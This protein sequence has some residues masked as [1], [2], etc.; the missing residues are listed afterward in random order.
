MDGASKMRTAMGPVSKKITETEVTFL[1]AS[2]AYYALVGL[3]PILLLIFVFT[4]LAA[5]DGVT[6]RLGELIHV[7]LTPLGQEMVSDLLLNAAVRDSVTVASLVVL[8][9]SGVKLFRG[10]NVAFSMVYGVKT[11]GTFLEK[12]VR[13]ALVVLAV[14]LV[15]VGLGIV[16]R[17][18]LV[19]P[20][21][22]LFGLQTPLT[23]FLS[24]LVVFLPLYY[25]LPEVSM[26]VQEAVPGSAVA[27]FGW[28]LL[29]SFF[30]IYAANAG[31]YGIYGVLGGVFLLAHWL[32]IGAIVLILG[33]VV[34][35]VFAE[36]RYQ[37][38]DETTALDNTTGDRR[39]Q[40]NVIG[41]GIGYRCPTC[42]Y[43]ISEDLI[44]GETIECWQCETRLKIDLHL[45]PLNGG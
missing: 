6:A 42:G 23:I 33:A 43:G 28:T 40:V 18:Q 14:V 13:T 32:Y 15:V 39:C 27:A 35:A 45:I 12:V 20:E 25:F 4:T 41:A 26:T 8:V 24:L 17:L 2:I 37:T 1:A 16:G 11:E 36:D 44:S 19:L 29:D 38:L 31:Q 7:F 9:W 10:L 22:L 3:I 21:L 30:G 5:G 34:N